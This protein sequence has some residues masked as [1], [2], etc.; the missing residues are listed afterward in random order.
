MGLAHEFDTILDAAQI[1]LDDPRIVIAFVGDGPKKPE[2][3]SA[4]AKRG[5]SNV[6]FLPFVEQ[7][8]LAWS[9]T[10][11]DVHLVTLNQG[12]VGLL[13]PSKIYGILAA[14]R[15]PIY[16]GPRDGEIHEIIETGK[17]GVCVSLGDGQGLAREIR[18]YAS[19]ARRK[20]DE[21]RRAREMFDRR[22]TKERSLNALV[23]LI[24]ADST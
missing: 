17:C 1:L 10:S 13:V 16:I 20:L 11:G 6:Q 15:P 2:L 21:G 23:R 22:F 14:G 7:H 5:L 4:V 24:N 19:D 18:A 12:M 3:E 9:L 8:E